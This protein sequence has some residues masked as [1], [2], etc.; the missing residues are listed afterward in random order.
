ML[1]KQLL[2][3]L[4][5]EEFVTDL[6]YD[7]ALL[8]FDNDG[9]ELEQEFY[10]HV[11]DELEEVPGKDNKEKIFNSAISALCL[12]KS[13]QIHFEKS[14]FN[15]ER[16]SDVVLD[17]KWLNTGEGVPPVVQ[18]DTKYISDRIADKNYDIKTIEDF[19]LKIDLKKYFFSRPLVR[20]KTF[21]DGSVSWYLS[22]GA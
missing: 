21:P 12:W 13:W 4:E 20:T 16:Y 19:P 14:N 7:N 8:L 9:N 17:D 5:L 10:P 2:Q 6:A 11:C 15:K 1:F 3:K 18:L 22:E